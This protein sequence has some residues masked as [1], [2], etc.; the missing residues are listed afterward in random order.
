M[1]V[2]EARLEVRA[3]QGQGDRTEEETWGSSGSHVFCFR[4]SGVRGSV[5]MTRR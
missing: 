1:G 4:V 3:T 5:R 2:I